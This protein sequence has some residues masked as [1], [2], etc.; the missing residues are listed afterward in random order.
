MDSCQLDRKET[1]M[2]VPVPG[3]QRTLT[4]KCVRPAGR[5]EKK[6]QLK[7]VGASKLVEVARIELASGSTRQSGLHA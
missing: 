6:P 4:S 3:V 1:K 2:E 5:T 7:T